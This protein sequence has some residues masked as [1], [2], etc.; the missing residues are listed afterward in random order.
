MYDR[1]GLE[2]LDVVL[3]LGCGDGRWLLAAARRGCAGRGLD[4]NEDLLQ[5]GRLA[6]ADAGVSAVSLFG[7]HRKCLDAVLFG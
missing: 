2:P 4:L 5:R 7:L 6:A 1:V 3:D